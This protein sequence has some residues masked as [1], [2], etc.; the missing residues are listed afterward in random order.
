MTTAEELAMSGFQC[1]RNNIGY[2]YYRNDRT[3]GYWPPEYVELL[4]PISTRCLIGYCAEQDISK[5][6]S[7]LINFSHVKYENIT[8]QN[9]FSRSL[10]MPVDDVGILNALCRRYMLALLDRRH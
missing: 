1:T 7:G 4:E 8:L 3:R 2:G 10:L 5:Q 6:R 9:W